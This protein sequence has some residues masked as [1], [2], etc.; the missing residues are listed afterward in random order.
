MGYKL[1][2]LWESE[3]RKNEVMHYKGKISRTR[4]FAKTLYW[5]WGE[6]SLVIDSTTFCYLNYTVNLRLEMHLMDV[7]ITYLY[8]SLDNN[9]CVKI[10]EWLKLPKEYDLVLEDFI[11]QVISIFI[12][13][14]TS[15]SYVVQST[16]WIF[17]KTRL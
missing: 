12:W 14:E 11:H 3:M 17:I 2:F 13:I 9:I 7:V 5:L 6:Y 15:W 10:L 16:R 4:L 8:S 1:V